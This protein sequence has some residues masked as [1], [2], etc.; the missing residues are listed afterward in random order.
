M[1]FLRRDIARENGLIAPDQK[2]LKRAQAEGV[3]PTTAERALAIYC[4]AVPASADQLIEGEI[5]SKS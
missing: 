4:S 3:T 5:E 2:T 1:P